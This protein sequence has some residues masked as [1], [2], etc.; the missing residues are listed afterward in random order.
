MDFVPSNDLDRA[1]LA[2][3]ESPAGMPE[4]YRQLG[5]GELFL[6][7][8]YHP[9]FAEGDR[10]KLEEG[11]AFP[12]VMQRDNKGEVVLLFSSEERAQEGMRKGK[13][14]PNRYI[15]IDMDAKEIL[16]VLGKMGMRALINK[17]CSTPQ[18]AIPPDLMRDI[19]SGEIF[20][21]SPLGD[22]VERRLGILAPE[23][24]PTQLLEPLRLAMR[25]HRNFRAAWIFK[26][27]PEPGKE[28]HSR[29]YQVLLYMDPPD[30]VLYHDFQ[31]V[32]GAAQTKGESVGFGLV[33]EDDLAYIGQLFATAEPFYLADEF[34]RP[35][36]G[37]S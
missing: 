9:E 28:S 21:V 29:R 10:F 18:I 3:H 16:G 33:D 4:F 27:S 12:F 20:R 31:L 8:P 5:E 34:V 2:A 22:T 11:M 35:R 32:V 23:D 36:S 19:A 17:S 14:P 13:V 6:L 1:L 24:Y 26:D 7:I 15:V 37:E 25:E 30:D